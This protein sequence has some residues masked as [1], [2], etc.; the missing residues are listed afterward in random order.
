MPEGGRILALQ[1][2]VIYHLALTHNTDRSYCCETVHSAISIESNKD[3]SPTANPTDYF[4]SEWGGGGE[5]T[6]VHF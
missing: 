4:A 2:I 5:F 6:P 3:E 1:Q